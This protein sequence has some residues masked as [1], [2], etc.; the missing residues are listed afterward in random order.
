LGKALQDAD[1][2]EALGVLGA[3]RNISC[4]TLMHASFFDPLDPWAQARPLDDKRFS[5]DHYE[6]KLF[7]L[8]SMMNTEGGKVEAKRRTERLRRLL[9]ELGEEIGCP[10]HKP[11]L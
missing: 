8:E 9:I 2:L 5:V 11:P 4:G 7:K 10:Y 3:F 6:C 1:R